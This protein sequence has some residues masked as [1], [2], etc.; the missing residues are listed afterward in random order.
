MVVGQSDSVFLRTM[1]LS[2]CGAGA[3]LVKRNSFRVLRPSRRPE[4]HQFSSWSHSSIHTASPRLGFGLPGRGLRRQRQRRLLLLIPMNHLQRSVVQ[5]ECLAALGEEIP[6]DKPIDRLRADGQPTTATAVVKQTKSREKTTSTVETQRK[7]AKRQTLPRPHPMMPMNS[8]NS[9]RT[10]SV[11]SF[12]G[13]M[14]FGRPARQSAR[15]LQAG[16]Q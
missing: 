9:S 3:T 8:T 1:I 12:D 16:Q 2:H 11:R 5:A 7:A 10:I 14:Q 6:R 13:L 4:S 15:G